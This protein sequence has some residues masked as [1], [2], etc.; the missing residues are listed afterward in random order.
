M[1][2]K[3]LEHEANLFAA[4]LLIPE[5][6]LSQELE[7]GVDLGN[8]NEFDRLCKKFDVPKNLML[9]RL[10]ILNNS[11]KVSNFR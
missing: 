4:L 9:Y 6:F 7:K 1:T 11:K 2:N 5:K 10:K 3:T 8:D